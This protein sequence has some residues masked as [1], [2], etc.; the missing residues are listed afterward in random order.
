M[1]VT[2]SYTDKYPTL[3]QKEFYEGSDVVML[4]LYKLNEVLFEAIVVYP[5]EH[6]LLKTYNF[7]SLRYEYRKNSFMR[8]IPSEKNKSHKI[9]NETGFY[10]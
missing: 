9:F 4:A 5:R 6:I 2:L 7:E 10:R 8:F 1:Q 3:I